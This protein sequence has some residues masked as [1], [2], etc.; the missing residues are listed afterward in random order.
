L[1]EEKYIQKKIKQDELDGFTA[2]TMAPIEIKRLDIDSRKNKLREDLKASLRGLVT[3]MVNEK[4]KEE[5]ENELKDKQNVEHEIDIDGSSM[6]VPPA[7][8]EKP[9]ETKKLTIEEEIEEKLEEKIKENEQYKAVEKEKE[10]IENQFKESHKKKEELEKEINSINSHLSIDFGEDGEYRV[11]HGKTFSTKIGDYTYEMTAFDN[12]KQKGT[13][14]VN[15]G[16]WKKWDKNRTLMVYDN[17]EK[18][19]NGP[20]RSISVTVICG[21][22]DKISDVREPSKCEYSMIFA[23]PSACSVEFINKL[24]EEIK[25]GN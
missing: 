22:E 25:I 2:Q 5:K 11:L 1:V 14:H 19:W 15:L 17:G 9:K 6:E 18:C 23:T 21:E 24:K 13:S 10:E 3:Q 20:Q 12:V 8:I 16:S 7:K 4:V